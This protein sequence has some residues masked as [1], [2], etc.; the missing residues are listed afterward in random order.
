[1]VPRQKR[2]QWLTKKLGHLFEAHPAV[3]AEFDD[4]DIPA[5]MAIGFG[6]LWITDSG[7]NLVYRVGPVATA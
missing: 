3:V 6:S 7:S 5:R 4:V 2:T 1:M